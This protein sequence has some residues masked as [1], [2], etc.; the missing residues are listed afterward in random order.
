MTDKYRV[1]EIAKF[2]Y[3][4][5]GV[6][7]DEYHTDT[8][9]MNYEVVDL[10]NRLTKE[11]EQLKQTIKSVYELLNG[12]VD[13]FSDDATE[14]DDNIIYNELLMLDNEDAYCIVLARKKAITLLKK[15][16]KE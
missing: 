16:L 2:N 8:P 6:Y 13:V 4:D 7:V 15:E 5:I 11:N 14:D 9:L 3:S 10:L 1:H 12:D